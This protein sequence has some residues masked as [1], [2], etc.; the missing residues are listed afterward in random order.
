[1]V[2]SIASPKGSTRILNHFL[3]HAMTARI[4]SSPLKGATASSSPKIRNTWCSRVQNQYLLWNRK[5]RLDASRMRQK[6][7]KSSEIAS[8][9]THSGC[10]HGIHL[11]IHYTRNTKTGSKNS[12]YMM[13]EAT[14]ILTWETQGKSRNLGGQQKGLILMNSSELYRNFCMQNPDVNMHLVQVA[15]MAT[16]TCALA[17]FTKTWWVDYAP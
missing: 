6:K 12:I 9:W 3:F 2:H 17:W 13:I 11:L 14:Q 7:Q 15:V 16:T 8:P 1:M 4:C 10:P 5:R